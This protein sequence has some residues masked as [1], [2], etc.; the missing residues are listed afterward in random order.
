MPASRGASCVVAVAG[1]GAGGPVEK[2]QPAVGADPQPPVA[3]LKQDADPVVAE[4]RRVRGIVDVVHEALGGAIPSIEPVHGSHPQRAGRVFE[5][6]QHPIVGEARRGR[7]IVA[8]VDEGPGRAVVPLEPP[9]GCDPQVPTAVVIDRMDPVTREA[10]GVGRIVPEALE[11]TARPVEAVEPRGEGADPEISLTVD[12]DGL[13]ASAASFIAM[14][15]DEIRIAQSAMMMIHDAWGVAI[16]N[17]VDMQAMADVLEKL[18]GQIA[19]IYANR[20]GRKANTFRRLMDAETWFTSEEAVANKLADSV[21]DAKA[22]NRHDLSQ[23]KNA[24]EQDTEQESIPLKINAAE[25]Q[26]RLRVLE[27]DGHEFTEQ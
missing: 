27:L 7:G 19:D 26:R 22:E 20:S 21:S 5:D 11:R 17:S 1:E 2:I 3:V 10:R 24:P 23:F 18:D 14:A 12:V 13:A 15:G 9:K 25:V 6:R 4:A 8:V 16:G